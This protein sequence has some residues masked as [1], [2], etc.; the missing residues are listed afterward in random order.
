[1]KVYVTPK[2]DKFRSVQRVV[3][4]L[5]FYAPSGI[6]LV[7]RQE[8]ADLVVLHVIGRQDSTLATAK[9]LKELGQQYVVIQYAVRSTMRP[10]TGGWLPLWRDA[11]LVWSYLDLPMLCAEDGNASDFPFYHAPLGVDSSTFYPR[12]RHQRQYVI[13][14]HGS[15]AV[16]EGIREAC[17]AAKRVRRPVFHLGPELKR[18]LDIMCFDDVDDSKLA[19]FLSQC[20][21]VACLRRTEGFELPAAEGLLCGARPICFDRAHY[22]QWYDPWAVFIPEGSRDNVI[23]TLESLF[24]MGARPVTD[25]EREVA[26]LVFN[27]DTIITEFW[28]KI[29]NR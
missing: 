11:M 19:G 27:W 21:H 25:E 17:F 10:L 9:C 5:D 18:G 26:K 4:A 28:D 1:M 3:S 2:E 6:G 29:I 15:A 20:E 22:R 16:F 14:T 23:D 13:G 7:E 24:I 12:Y 8:E